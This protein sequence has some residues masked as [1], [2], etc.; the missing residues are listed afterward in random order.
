M[1]LRHHVHLLYSSSSQASRRMG[2]WT[3]PVPLHNWPPL[4]GSSCRHHY[5]GFVF[6]AFPFFLGPPWAGCTLG[7]YRRSLCEEQ[8]RH[9]GAGAEKDANSMLKRAHIWGTGIWGLSR[10]VCFRRRNATVRL[11]TG[12]NSFTKGQSSFVQ[13]N[14][15]YQLWHSSWV[16]RSVLSFFAQKM[17]MVK[18]LTMV[19]TN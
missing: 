2:K 16:W 14:S 12:Q 19:A 5:R 7:S 18:V 11:I 3:L 17:H 10:V 13:E 1:S 4:C 9:C 6:H 8:E 15:V